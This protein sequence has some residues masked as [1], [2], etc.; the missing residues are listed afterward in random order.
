MLRRWKA[1]R[2]GEERARAWW[3]RHG[4]VWTDREWRKIRRNSRAMERRRKELSR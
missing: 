1:R 4:V 2:E 3:A